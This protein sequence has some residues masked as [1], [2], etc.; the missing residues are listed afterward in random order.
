[1]I[2][3][4][5]NDAG[6]L[7][8]SD[9]GVAVTEDTGQFSPACDAIWAADRFELVPQ[10]LQ[11][12]RLSVRVVLACFLVSLLYNAVGLTLA[13]RGDLSPLSSAILMPTSSLSVIVS[14][15]IGTRWAA[16]RAGLG[17]AA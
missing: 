17:R 16:R 2:G 9:A 7:K 6:A 14:A 8:Q 1:M 5:L 4:G 3:D 12:A 10:V 11:F 13:C 15:L